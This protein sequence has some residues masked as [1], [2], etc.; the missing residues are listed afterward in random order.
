M[1]IGLALRRAHLTGNDQTPHVV[2]RF[3]DD[4][5]L[6]KLMPIRDLLLWSSASTGQVVTRIYEY[7]TRPH[8]SFRS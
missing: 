3:T 2:L 5:L 4:S 1:M 8:V 6:D 7:K